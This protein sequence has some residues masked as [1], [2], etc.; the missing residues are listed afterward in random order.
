M[1]KLIITMFVIL[2]ISILFISCIDQEDSH[3]LTFEKDEIVLEIGNH[4]WSI[5]IAEVNRVLEDYPDYK[6]EKYYTF[7]SFNRIKIIF[8]KK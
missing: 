2:I 6:I 5:L 7:L 4:D 1:K 8:I 3:Q